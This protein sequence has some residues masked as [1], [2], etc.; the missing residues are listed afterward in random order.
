MR[1]AGPLNVDATKTADYPAIT[2][3]SGTP[4]VAWEES[5]GTVS[6]IR[7]AQ[8]TVGGLSLVGLPLN[9]DST[10][11][12]TLPSIADVGGVPYVAWDESSGSVSQVRVADLVNG[13]WTGVG[14][15][16]NLDP[17]KDA[18]SPSIA[19]V[20][21]VPYVAWWEFNGSTFD[22]RVKKLFAGNGVSVGNALN[23]NSGSAGLFPRI[24]D[25]GGVPYVAWTELPSG[26]NST[27]QVYVDKFVNGAWT[28]LGG[29]LNAVSTDTSLDYP[30]IVDIGGNP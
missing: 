26:P 4:Y 20:G 11:N 23:V 9:A 28:N 29:S 10:Q 17:T 14:G 30:D 15:V 6:L 22:I 21:G 8:L 27:Y 18:I 12:A 5:N 3:V 1:S 7:V 13:V 24:A 19:D 25:V 16:L 2:N